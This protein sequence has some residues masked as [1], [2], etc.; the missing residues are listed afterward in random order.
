MTKKFRIF[1]SPIE[2]QEK[3][4]NDRAAEG[5]KLFKVGRFFYEFKKC[6][7]GQYQYAV[8]YIGNFSN[9]QRK[10]Y[11]R[12]L[13]EMRICYYEKPL[14]LGQFSL[15][16][17]KYRP[18]ANRGGKLATSGRM[19]DRELLILERENSGKPFTIFTNV[20]DKIASLKERKKPHYYLLIFILFMELYINF[21][22]DS[23]IDISYLSNRNS[24]FPNDLILSILFGGVGLI[25]IVRL[26]QLSLSIKTLKE[27]EEIHE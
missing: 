4:L 12:F 23:L 14:N 3:W 13:D 6:K 15:G 20:K 5:L 19:I 22:G 21:V 10:D 24:H 2:G 7:P 16:R 11:E 9:K 27:K 8:D 1:M 26:F 18:Y 17:V 25:P